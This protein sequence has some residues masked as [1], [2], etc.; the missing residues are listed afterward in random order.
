MGYIVALIEKD[1]HLE[2]LVEKLC[3]RF[4]ATHSE[5]QWRDLAYCLSLFPFGDKA[6]KK[7][8]VTKTI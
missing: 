5:R 6:V 8:Q 1:K 4:R 7:L 3:H 2:S